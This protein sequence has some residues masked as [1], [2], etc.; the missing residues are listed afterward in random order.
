MGL[1]VK[2]ART[3]RGAFRKRT[4]RGGASRREDA[5]TRADG[6]SAPLSNLSEAIGELQQACEQLRTSVGGINLDLEEKNENLK[7]ALE[8]HGETLA[9]VENIIANIPNGVVVVD[10]NGRV[11][12]LNS[13]AESMTGYASAEL[14]GSPYANVLGRGVPEKSTPLYTLATGS[15]VRQG[16]KTLATR[17]GRSVPV[18][19]STSLILDGHNDI[20]GAVEVLTDLTRMRLLE[21]EVSRTRTL[22]TIG[23][24]AAMVAHEIR[25]PLGGIKGFASL[26]KRDLAS[27]P[28]SLAL[29]EKISEGIDTLENIVSDLLTAGLPVKLERE[30]IELTREVRKLIEMFELAAG[31][32]DQRVRFEASFSEEPFYCKVDLERMKQA[33]TNLFRNAMDAVCEGGRV[34]V[35]LKA[36]DCGTSESPN[37]EKPGPAREYIHIEVADTGPGIPADVLERVFS[38]FFT[39]KRGG[40]GLGL[41]NVRKIAALHGGEVRYER[42]ERGGSRFIM[43]IPRW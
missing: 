27:R 4:K 5:P 9:Y 43:E 38:P 37:G 39:T 40:S 7:T 26:L 41:A 10:R 18:S 24:V 14:E 12:L 23:E 8:T 21:E 33:L 28:D 2:E 31:G 16:E 1:A 13:A 29:V 3:D 17:S 32:E 20:C 19:Y 35:S 15:P 6:L 30:R 42:G 36:K 25:N 34:T 22:A 11:V